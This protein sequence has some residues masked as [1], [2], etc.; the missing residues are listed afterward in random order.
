MPLSKSE[1]AFI[2]AERRRKELNELLR[3]FFF[4]DLFVSYGRKDLHPRVRFP[5]RVPVEKPLLLR[6]TVYR[7]RNSVSTLF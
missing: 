7:D 6:K 2:L 1:N 5:F 3:K 4:G